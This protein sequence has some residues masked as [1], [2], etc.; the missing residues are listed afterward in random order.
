MRQN[1]KWFT[2]VELVVV[3]VILSILATVWFISYE[4]YLTDTRDS[5]RLAQMS[6]LRDG[7][8]LWI[9]KWKLPLPDDNVE[10]R[11]NGTP[12]LYQWYA[13]ENVLEGISYSEATKDPYDDTYYTYLLSRNRKDF[14]ILGFL[15]EYNPDVISSITWQSF[16]AEDYSQRFP[17]VM[18]KK[19]WILLEQ[20]TNTPLQEMSGYT[21]SWYIDLQDTTTN[22]FDAYVTDTQLISGKGTDLIGI[23]PFTT[24]KKIKEAGWS[25]WNGI[26]NINP[27]GLNPFEVYC[28][29]ELDE[30]WWTLLG[31]SVSGYSWVTNFWWIYDTWNIR[32]D[33]IPYSLGIDSVSINFSEILYSTYTTWKDITYADLITVDD[34]YLKNN[35][36]QQATDPD[37]PSHTT[38]LL[39]CTTIYKPTDVWC[40]TYWSTADP[41][42]PVCTACDN[43][44]Y[45][46]VAWWKFS[47]SGFML[48]W[49]TD[50][51][52]GLESWGIDVWGWHP[53]NWKQWMIF[54]R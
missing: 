20:D 28:N 29:M 5:K 22:L 3:A 36:D 54:V 37:D 49:R 11:N 32:D 18:G 52:N 25:Y 43:Y 24:C 26:Y 31:R 12:F 6:G 13:G 51:E 7:L 9:T 48:P 33:G 39:G 50:Y 41:D 1:S 2:L 45:D 30:W 44:T 16:A 8:R 15:E 19:L 35:F 4:D 34:S 47:L 40:G 17:Q 27:S 10:I 53:Y 38:P 14:Q 21:S 46:P 23:I 42:E